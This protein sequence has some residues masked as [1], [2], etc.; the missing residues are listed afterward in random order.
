[1]QSIKKILLVWMLGTVAF[2]QQAVEVSDIIISDLGNDLLKISIEVQNTSS[3]SISEIAGYLEI[4]DKN[5]I[6]VDKQEVSVVL[7][8]DV[9]LRPQKTA[10]RHV[11]ITQRPN[12]S[13]NARFRITTLRFFGETDVYLVCP[14]CGEL[15][16][17]N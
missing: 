15:I 4:Y 1:M 16:P 9:P 7:K 8:S 5:S 11:I 10:S 12:M 17:K 13:G 14:N 2:A 6:V 3:K